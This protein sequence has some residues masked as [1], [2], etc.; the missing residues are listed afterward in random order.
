M[1]A[2]LPKEKRPPAGMVSLHIWSIAH[3]IASLFARGDGARRKI[4][5]SP[6]ELL[7]AGILV[8]LRGLGIGSD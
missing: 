3:G 5:M 8:Y 7:E 6:E 2:G 4:P 1:I